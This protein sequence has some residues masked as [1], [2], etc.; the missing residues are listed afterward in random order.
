MKAVWQGSITFG[1]VN[2]PIKLYNV[3]EPKQ[4]S[5]HLLCGVCKSPLKYQRYCPKCKKEVVWQNVLHGFEIEKGKWKAF[6]KDE[7]VKLKPSGSDQIEILGFTTADRFDAILFSKHYYVVPAKIKEKAYFLLRDIL[8]ATAK[9]AY[10]RM[11]LHEKEHIVLIRPYKSG[12]LLT[13]LHYVYELRDI[14]TI[15]DLKEKVSISKEEF[16]LA[17]KLVQS[18]TKEPELDTYKDSFE[19]KLKE[20]IFGKSKAKPA[21]PKPEKLLEALKLSIK[22]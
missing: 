21:K 4:F 15:A 17:K 5:F 8:R 10:G 22:K 1:L 12:L 14:N 9:V 18:L 3:V 16:E 20:I 11:I 7:L 2:I 19:Q 6:K 13:T